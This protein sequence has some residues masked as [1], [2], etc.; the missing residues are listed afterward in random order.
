MREPVDEARLRRFLRALGEH[1]AREGACYLTGGATAVLLG[2]RTTTVDVDMKLVPEQDEVLRALPRLKDELRTNV[3]LVSPGDFIPLPCGWEERSVSA[4]REGRLSFY[5]FDPYAQALA[6]LE[7]SH[8]RDLEDVAAMLD[9]RLVDGAR[10][11]ELFE[12][13][14]PQLYRFPA[15]HPGRF[16]ERV[17]R[18]ARS[19]PARRS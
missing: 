8:P 19:G 9:R 6:K 4:G 10:H 1:A 11:T 3:E 2:W 7:R 14:A 18:A 16:R 5:H 13:I 17:R 12:E 15:V